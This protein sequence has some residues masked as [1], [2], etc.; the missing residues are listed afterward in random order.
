MSFKLNRSKRKGITVMIRQK[1]NEARG[2]KTSKHAGGHQPKKP[3]NQ[4]T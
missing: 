3:R 4:R 1:F 2:R